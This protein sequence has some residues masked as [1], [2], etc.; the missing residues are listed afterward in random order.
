MT[1]QMWDGVLTCYHLVIN[2]LEEFFVD[3][4]P[5]ANPVAFSI[6]AVEHDELDEIS[7]PLEQSVDFDIT[8]TVLAWRGLELSQESVRQL[9]RATTRKLTFIRRT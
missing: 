1:R 7:L 6:V 8:V 3:K 2:V 4:D 5:H 9:E